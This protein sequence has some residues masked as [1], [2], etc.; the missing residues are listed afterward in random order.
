MRNKNCEKNEVEKKDIREFAAQKILRRAKTIEELRSI[1]RESEYSIEE[2]DDTIED[3]K[4]LGYLDDVRYSQSYFEY[5][6]RKGWA[7]ARTIRELKKKGVEQNDLDIALMKREVERQEEREKEKESDE[8]IFFERKLDDNERAFSVANKMA[9]KDDLEES[10]R[11]SEKV[12]ARI[13]RRLYGYGYSSDTIF[14]TIR[15]L[16]EFLRDNE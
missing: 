9:D 1:L 5:A 15:K 4:A 13:A 14:S 12:K 8:G 2:I 16:E 3:F 11:L 6:G 7:D 10:G